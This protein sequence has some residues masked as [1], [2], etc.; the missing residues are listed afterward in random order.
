MANIISQITNKI[1]G[2]R[3]P[4]HLQF[5]KTDCG[6]SCIKIILKYF[7]LDVSM[8]YIK[9]KCFVDLQGANIVE[10]SK[11]LQHF[12]LE[13][14]IVKSDIEQIAFPEILPAILL[15]DNKHYVVLYKRSKKGFHISDPEFGKYILPVDIFCERWIIENHKG[16]A[17]LIDKPIENLQIAPEFA[18]PKVIPL[19]YSKYIKQNLRPL[20]AV[21]VISILA[22]L[23]NLLFPILTQKIVDEAV[24]KKNYNLVIFIVTSQI[25]I[26]LASTVFNFIKEKIFI[27]LISK[28]SISNLSS[29]L[30][31]LSNIPF[32]FFELKNISD[33]IQR[34]A[35]HSRIDNFVTTNVS[36][37]IYAIINVVGFSYLL[38]KY[39]GSLL[40]VLFVSYL[41]SFIWT[42]A[43]TNKRNLIEYKRFSSYKEGMNSSYEI[44]QGMVELKLNSAEDY[45]IREWKVRQ[46]NIFKIQEEALL[47]ETKINVGN[48]LISQ[49]KNAIIT[50][51]CAFLVMNNK[52]TLGEMLGI[53]FIIG[54]L[55]S[56]LNT[57][58]EFIKKWND[59]KYSFSRINEINQM[60]DEVSIEVD[61]NLDVR[62]F[63]TITFSKVNF[64]YV[65]SSMEYI[66]KDVNLEIKRGEKV[67]FV[68]ASGGGKSTSMKLLL[69]LYNPSN[70]DILVDQKKLKGIYSKNWR[71][72]YGVVMQDGY[73]FNGSILENIILDKD[74]LDRKKLDFVCE[75]ACI[76]S[77]IDSL[78]QG[79]DY[80]LG[81]RGRGL[82]GGQLQRILIARALYKDAP[83]LVFDEATSSL[84]TLNEAK[85]MDNIFK[86]YDDKTIVI[87]AHRLSTIKNVDNIYVFDKGRIVEKG[88][89]K[90][91]LANQNYYYNLVK[92]QLES[93]VNPLEFQQ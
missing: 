3:F 43:F 76:R 5:D 61:S 9:E 57:F 15:F 16:V 27:K 60:R 38:L 67:A 51:L 81:N 89:H 54:A 75:I 40:L 64:K 44:V 39:N 93:D 14:A 70:G 2:K 4:N 69:K 46:G 6:P 23:G 31:K 36:S 58:L 82:S 77:Y 49:L 34:L 19:F 62:N 72:N 83:I 50:L 71:E 17:I 11:G 33:L 10:I 42:L 80:I 68:G 91:L 24:P 26:I 74:K 21:F 7:K 13:T 47:L 90:Q 53:S 65:D 37:T 1:F 78:P 79:Y 8:A 55:S 59:T 12:G 35:D 48:I 20:L 87:I 30:R 86:H 73:I 32:R 28:L 84:D 66:L 25:S 18:E 52:M 88:S 22:A 41:I 45:R 85:I 63:K 92:S 29:F 56:P